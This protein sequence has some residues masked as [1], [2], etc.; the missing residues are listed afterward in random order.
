MRSSYLFVALASFALA[1]CGDDPNNLNGGLAG[2]RSRQ[3]IPGASSSGGVGTD[4]DTSGTSGNNG[5][6]TGG[7]NSGGTSGGT[8][9]GG[10]SGTAPQ[11]AAGVAQ[12]CVDEINKYRAKMGLPAYARWTEIEACSDGQSQ[13]DG[14]TGRAHGSFPK[15]G[16]MAQNECPGWDGPAD[17][18]LPGCLKMMWDEGPGGG[19]YEN[20]RSQKYTKVACGVH[21]LPNGKVW[22]VQNFK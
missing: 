19:H 10:T 2:R 11:G 9:T 8:P 21:T 17:K 3:G 22:S 13:S 12:L 20:M 14:Q 6:S 1:A 18:M 15:C 5:G 7:T 16:E 4:D